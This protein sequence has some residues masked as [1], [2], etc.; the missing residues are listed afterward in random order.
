MIKEFA[1]L[2]F[3]N[4]CITCNNNL[5]KQEEFI[6]S[7]C[8]YELPQ[9]D[10][11]KFPENNLAKTFWGRVP[12]EAVF[13]LLYFRKDGPVQALMHSLKYAGGKELAVFL[14]QYY[15]Q[16]L[17]DAGLIYD[18]VAAIPLHPDKLRKR[19][20]NQS[21]CFAQGLAQSMGME[22]VSFAVERAVATETQTKKDRFERWA[23][24]GEVFRVSNAEALKHKRLLVV[25]DVITTG[26][27]IEGLCKVILA[28]APC[29]IS[30]GAIATPQN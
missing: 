16:K 3:P 28:E 2:F 6:C 14:G 1:E 8:L 25:D 30:V 18:A 27:T 19:G 17:I 24:V 9:T 15:G 11:H 5:L 7:K 23:N 29:T 22:D 12:L 4:L 20:Y 26:A 10:Y 13:A 21:A